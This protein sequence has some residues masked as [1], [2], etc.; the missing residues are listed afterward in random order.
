MLRKREIDQ[1]YLDPYLNIAKD[2]PVDYMHAVLEGVTRTLL[3]N[4]WFDGKYHFNSFNLG[5]E[6]KKIDKMLLCIKPP[7]EFRRTPRSIAKSIK[8]WKAAE[9]RAWLFFHY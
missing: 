2:V 5:T 8:Y 4:Y 1:Y 7:H 6:L 9:W 3:M